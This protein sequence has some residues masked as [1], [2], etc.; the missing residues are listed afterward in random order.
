M[1][2]Y[3]WFKT[4]F[5]WL[6]A[7]YLSTR[8]LNNLYFASFMATANLWRRGKRAMGWMVRGSRGWIM[9]RTLRRRMTSAETQTWDLS[10]F[11]PPDFQAK[12]FI[13][14]N[15]PDFKHLSDKNTKKWVQ[16]EK[17]TPLGKILRCS[18]Q[19]RH[20][21]ISPLKRPWLQCQ[22][23]QRGGGVQRQEEKGKY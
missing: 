23:C 21:Q 6:K 18:R 12:K 13:P 14:S 4:P 16:M 15:S 1:T 7:L 2:L 9:R 8:W 11:T 17:F 3:L 20:G 5:L 22:Q 10:N 19:W